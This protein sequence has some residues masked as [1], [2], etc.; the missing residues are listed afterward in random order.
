ML[1][2]MEGNPGIQDPDSDYKETRPPMRVNI[3]RDRA[4]DL[5]VSVQEI[6]RTLETMMG[7]RQVTTYVDNGEEYDVMLQAGRENRTSP[8]DLSLIHI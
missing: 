8:E 7:S 2:R 4:A 1:V 6:G 5:G 3:N